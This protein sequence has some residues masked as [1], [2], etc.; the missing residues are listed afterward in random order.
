VGDRAGDEAEEEEDTVVVGS[1]S[2]SMIAMEGSASGVAEKFDGSLSLELS[3]LVISGED[4]GNISKMTRPTGWWNDDAPRLEGKLVPVRP[5]LPEY[6]INKTNEYL[7]KWSN[8]LFG[9]VKGMLVALVA[10]SE[11]VSGVNGR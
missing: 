2:G 8:S 3:T 9:V 10:S 7:S 6:K 4:P 1:V 11:G 5:V